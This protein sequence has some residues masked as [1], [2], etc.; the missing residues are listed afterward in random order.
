MDGLIDSAK[1]KLWAVVNDLALAEPSPRLEVALLT[2]GNDGHNAASPGWVHVQTPF[3]DDLD[4]VSERLFALRTNGGTEY[5][6]RV[7]SRAGATRLG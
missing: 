5:V 2:F 6:G 4:V 3:T 7:L 1:Q